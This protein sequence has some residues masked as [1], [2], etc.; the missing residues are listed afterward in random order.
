MDQPNHGRLFGV[1]ASQLVNENEY[2]QL[3]TSNNVLAR[4]GVEWEEEDWQGEIR[5]IN[6]ETRDKLNTGCTLLEIYIKRHLIVKPILQV[7]DNS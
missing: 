4:Q 3:H 7:Q 5:G 6:V 2:N 1:V